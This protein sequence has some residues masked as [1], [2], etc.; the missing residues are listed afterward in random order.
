MHA[1]TGA[2]WDAFVKFWHGV[3]N[4]GTQSNPSRARDLIFQLQSNLARVVPDYKLLGCHPA[5]LMS[6]IA[7]SDVAPGAIRVV[8]SAK[9]TV[10][11][12]KRYNQQTAAADEA[13]FSCPNCGSTGP[14]PV[15]A[16][17]EQLYYSHVELRAALRSAC[18]QMLPLE[19]QGNRSLD[20]SRKVLRRADRIYR[21]LNSPKELFDE[22]KPKELD[23]EPPTLVSGL[24][25]KVLDGQSR[26]T[27]KRTRSRLMRPHALRFIR[28]PGS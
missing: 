18:R 16:V 25:L 15:F 8:A 6:L 12:L 2:T 22:L 26:P 1:S 7:T 13:P 3:L 5:R 23:G 21:M 17:V 27:S 20:R 24:E 10:E 4:H 9:M 28:P 19:K 14:T 11:K